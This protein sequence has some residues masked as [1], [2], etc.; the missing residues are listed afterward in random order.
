MRDAAGRDDA[1]DGSNTL[2]AAL[3]TQQKPVDGAS[4]LRADVSG[5]RGLCAVELCAPEQILADLEGGHARVV[6]EVDAEL[7]HGRDAGHDEV[8]FGW[9][10]RGGGG[11][12]FGGAVG[13]EGQRGGPDCV[14]GEAVEDV[15]GGEGG[16]PGGGV[17]GLSVVEA[18]EGAGCCCGD[19]GCVDGGAGVVLDAVA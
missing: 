15:D 17:E 2:A 5:G 18:C 19:G 4:L 3:V 13:G 8:G 10:G 6:E 12:E 9:E 7:L 11:A 1:V 14:C 16:G